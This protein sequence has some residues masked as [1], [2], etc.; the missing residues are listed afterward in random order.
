MTSIRTVYT[1]QE[2]HVVSVH[3]Y[4][5][6]E[7]PLVASLVCLSRTGWSGRLKKKRTLR[8]ALLWADSVLDDVVAEFD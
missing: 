4:T 2:P 1:T 7:W 6:A 8:I 5:L 3:R